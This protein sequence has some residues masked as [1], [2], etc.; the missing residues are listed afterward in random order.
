MMQLV[1]L[2]IKAAVGCKCS[3]CYMATFCLLFW[4]GLT[5]FHSPGLAP[6]PGPR[7]TS[8]P[9][10]SR[11]VDWLRRCSRRRLCTSGW[12]DFLSRERRRNKKKKCLSNKYIQLHHESESDFANRR[13]M[14]GK[15]FNETGWIISFAQR[16]PT[17]PPFGANGTFHHRRRPSGQSHWLSPAAIKPPWTSCR[18][19]SD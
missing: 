19:P 17:Q 10:S 6:H 3:S 15:T 13:R 5:W 8:P 16:C 1:I 4:T 7:W 12:G 9:S 2:E 11:W 14:K 18:P